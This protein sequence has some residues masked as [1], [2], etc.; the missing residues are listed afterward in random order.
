MKFSLLINMKMPTLAGIF[1]SISREIF[2]LSRV[3]YEK[4]FIT[5][6]LGYIQKCKVITNAG[7]FIFFSRETFI[8]NKVEHEKSYITLGLAPFRSAK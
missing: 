1:I 7:F 2:M 4:S 5:L 3:E 6:G 8:L